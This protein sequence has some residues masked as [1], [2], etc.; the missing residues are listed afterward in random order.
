MATLRPSRPAISRPGT[1]DA[2]FEVGDGPAGHPAQLGRRDRKHSVRRSGGRDQAV[3]AEEV[4]IDEDAERPGMA[5]GRHA[6]DCIACEVAHG[7]GVGPA[8]GLTAERGEATLVR[9]V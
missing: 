5:N 3:V 6:A 9:L 8:N 2:A 1:V 4:R 7:V